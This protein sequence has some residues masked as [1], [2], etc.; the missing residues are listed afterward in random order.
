[1]VTT[2]EKR[3]IRKLSRSQIS[4]FLETAG[5]QRFRAKQIDHWLW[6]KS[7]VTFEAMKNLPKSLLEKLAS[8]F[9]INPVVVDDRQDSTDGTIKAAFKLHDGYLVEGVLIPSRTRLTACISVQVGCSMT[10]TFCATAQLKR[11]RNLDAAEMR[12]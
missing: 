8:E 2:T 1:M 10:C 3:D 9:T 7:V 12:H 5:E 6:K 4:D 11:E